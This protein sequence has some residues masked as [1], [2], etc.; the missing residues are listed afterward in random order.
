M[1]SS[2]PFCS[3][4][5]CVI[6]LHIHN[7]N[8]AIIGLVPQGKVVLE[9]LHDEGRVLVLVLWELIEFLEGLIKGGLSKLLGLLGLL[10]D[11][12]VEDREVESEAEPDWV[13][14]LQEA[15]RGVL[16]DILGLR[17]GLQRKREREGGR[18]MR[19][20]ERERARG[21]VG[22][23]PSTHA[24][25]ENRERGGWVGQRCPSPP[26]GP[27]VGQG[28]GQQ[29]R[30]AKGLLSPHRVGTSEALFL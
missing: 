18:A 19:G 25:E 28:G 26:L 29:H 30:Q 3:P 23:A 14:F 9:E 2:P 11:L 20:R 12:V 10:A 17:V 27:T 24:R 21:W 6:C 1:V 13:C 4:P 8:L 22:E 16:A 15:R 5:G 7:L